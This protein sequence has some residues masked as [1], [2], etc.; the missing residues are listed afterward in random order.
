MK[1][2][3]EKLKSALKKVWESRPKFSHET[4]LTFSSL[5]IIFIIAFSIRLLPIRWGMSLSEFDPFFQYRFTEHI[6]NKGFLSWWPWY[7]PNRWYPLGASIDMTR[8]AFP[9]LPLTAAT[10]YTIV[11]FLGISISLKDFCIIFPPVFGALTC[12]ASYFLGKE[13]S[14]KTVGLLSALILALSP[15]HITRTSLGFFDDETVGLFS[16]I[17]LFTFF[18]RAIDDKRPIKSSLMYGILSG[19]TLGYLCASWGASYYPIGLITLFSLVL[20]LL[21]RFNERLFLTYSLIF[22][23]GLFIAAHVPKPGLAYL[24]TWPILIVA[25][26]FLLLCLNEVIRRTRTTKWKIIYFTVFIALIVAGFTSLYF[27]G[28]MRGIA[29]KFISVINPAAREAAPIVMS[30]QEHRL[31]S[32]SALYYE[33]G[34]ALVLALIGFFFT[35]GNLTKKNIFLIL[36]GIT[37]LYFSCSMVRLLVLSTPAIGLL[38]GVGTVGVLRPFTMLL[39]G[40]RILPTRKGYVG[41]IGKEFGAVPIFLCFILLMA[42]FAF[43]FPKVYNHAY[44]PTTLWAGSMPIR[45]QEP[46]T[47]WMDTLTWIRTTLPPDAVIFSW[48][49]YGYWITVEGNRT[50]LADNA[51]FNTTHIAIIGRVFVENETKALEI[52]KTIR[53]GDSPPPGYILVFT[54]VV[55]S[56]DYNYSYAGWGDMGK[57]MWMLRI[58]NSSEKVADV[59]GPIILSDYINETTNELIQNSKFY[60][61]LIYKLMEHARYYVVNELYNMNAP[62]TDPAQNSTFFREHFK[63]VYPN[64]TH[65]PRYAPY[66][67]VA[68]IIA[69]YKVEY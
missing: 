26:T 51:T 1:I 18:L 58:A 62:I 21:R 12:I 50:S 31:T 34:I 56:R 14:G 11:S 52:L 68:P 40:R 67:G 3:R 7:D 4:L 47:E 53:R 30:V 54:T 17:V 59:W 43:P 5:I 44:S 63:L 64:E 25:G 36:F 38:A 16:I 65:K 10:L 2:S 19:L 22:G 55:M 6:I 66:G 28:Y 45:P 46:V 57:W 29:G 60:D 24:T 23:I 37:A 33:Y 9:G 48:W 42:N 13:I 32:W 49:D 35:A 69:I 61:S 8:R 39:K 41:L 20:L 27:L 15:T